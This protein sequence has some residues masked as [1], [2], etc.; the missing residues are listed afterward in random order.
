MK[1]YVFSQEEFNNIMRQNGIDNSNV[2]ER[3]EVFYISINYEEDDKPY[4]TDKENVKVMFFD[5]VD[6]EYNAPVMSINENRVA[7]AFTR[8]QAKELFD[9]INKHKDKEVCIVH[10]TAGISRSGAVGQFINDYTASDKQWF[11]QQNRH[12]IPNNLVL[13]LLQEQ[14]ATTYKNNKP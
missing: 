6:Q 2:E 11:K 5:D 13:R 1:V 3:T 7:K 14:A 4:F 8:K 9:F 12:I 10:C